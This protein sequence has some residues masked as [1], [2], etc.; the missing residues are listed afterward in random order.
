MA[1]EQQDRFSEQRGAARG[2]LARTTRCVDESNQ[3]SGRLAAL[4]RTRP[5]QVRRR[6]RHRGA[7]P[8]RELRRHRGPTMQQRALRSRARCPPRSMPIQPLEVEHSC[9]EPE[10]P[11]LEGP[12][13]D[14][15][16]AGDGRQRGAVD[17][18]VRDCTQNDVDAGHFPRQ[19]LERQHALAVPTIATARDRH[20]ENHRRAATVQ[21]TLDSAPSKSQIATAACSAVTPSQQLVTRLI[22]DDGVLAKLEVEYEN[23]VLVTA[24]G[25]RKTS[26]A[27]VF[28]AHS[29][30]MRTRRHSRRRQRHQ[31]QR[32]AERDASLNKRE[33]RQ[34]A[35]P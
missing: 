30:R 3:P 19:R 9:A 31:R 10:H 2:E 4:F 32:D 27:V 25:V 5:T 26:G 6:E 35:A 17:N 28:L 18:R 11:D 29:A 34:V 16:R 14:A 8:P 33:S 20:R 13:Y 22:D 1:P 7:E 23:Q 15:R 12:R 21:P 24:P